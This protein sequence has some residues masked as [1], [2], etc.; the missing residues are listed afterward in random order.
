M[1]Q[2]PSALEPHGGLDHAPRMEGHLSRHGCAER[3]A[4][5]ATIFREDIVRELDVD[6]LER[7][8]LGNGCAS[9]GRHQPRQHLV[10][11]HRNLHGDL[12]HDGK[13]RRRLRRRLGRQVGAAAE[14][15]LALL[16]A[17][18]VVGDVHVG[19]HRP[20]WRASHARA[21]CRSR[22]TPAVA[23]RFPLLL[24]DGSAQ[25]TRGPGGCYHAEELFL[26]AS[27]THGTFTVH[28]VGVAPTP[29]GRGEW[30][31]GEVARLCP[32]SSNS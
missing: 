5:P 32:A 31:V 11:V 15:E 30:R 10:R 3:E 16:A 27:A 21:R 1:F 26:V 7:H 25:L 8:R 13:A 18:V 28:G 14:G 2:F 19:A 4:P 23:A 22:P 17:D 24:P 9:P 20:A 29:P 6:A 12:R